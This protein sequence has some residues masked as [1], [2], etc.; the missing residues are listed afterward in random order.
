MLLPQ[1]ASGTHTASHWVI[2]IGEGRGL[3][4]R[5]SS[6]LGASCGSSNNLRHIGI[7]VFGCARRCSGGFLTHKANFT[8]IVA[9][10]LH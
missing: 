5:T 3:K 4:S 1:G 7:T 9:S 8:Q 10:S 2:V 6:P